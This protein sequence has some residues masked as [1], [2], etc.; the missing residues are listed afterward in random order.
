METP[1]FRVEARDPG[2]AA[3]TGII[4]TAHGEVPT[5]AFMPVGTRGAVRTLDPREVEEAGATILLANTYHLYLRPG[6]DLVRERGG[7]HRFIGWN[8]P[9]LTD[10]GGFQ[11]FSLAPLRRVRDEGVLFRSHIDG[12]R[13][14]IGPERAIRIQAA[15]GTDIAMSF[16]ECAPYPCDRS[17]LE[18]AVRRTTEWA[19]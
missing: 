10:S 11:I 5:P 8:R 9:I 19:A 4:R 16:D 7:L 15:L 14:E 13:H 1:F 17:S 6:E 3:R 2:G 12:S 18:R